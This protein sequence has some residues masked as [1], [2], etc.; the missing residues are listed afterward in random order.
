METENNLSFDWWHYH[1]RDTALQ[2]FLLF[3][4]IQ[5]NRD[6]EIAAIIERQHWNLI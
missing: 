5:L 4:E 6:P 3:R 2:L 1:E